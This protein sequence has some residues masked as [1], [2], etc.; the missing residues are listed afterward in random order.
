MTLNDEAWARYFDA[1]LTLKSIKQRGYAYVTSNELKKIGQREARFMA[2]LDTLRSRPQVFKDN[3]LSIFPVK[4]GKYII[5]ED[6]DRKSY[7]EFSEQLDKVPVERYD[8]LVDLRS[9][10]S[11]PRGPSLSESQAID[12]AFLSSLLKSFTADENLRLTIR[13]T[14]YSGRFDFVLPE[15]GYQVHIS[16]VQIEIDAGYESDKAIYLIEAK[17]GKRDNFHIRQL[18]YPYLEWS[19]RSQ[20]DIVP[21]FF[22]YS[23][24]K[25]CLTEFSF[26]EKFG[27]LEIVRRDC[28]TINESPISYVDISELFRLIPEGEE[29]EGIPYPQAN[30]LDKVVDAINLIG[31]GA[32]DKTQLAEFFEFEGRQGDYYAN[33]GCYLGF[34]EREGRMFVLTHL[35][36][37]FVRL[38][39]FSERARSLLSQMLTRPTFRD[40]FNLLV[41]NGFRLENIENVKIAEIIASHT[42]LTGSTPLRRAST[43]RSWIE[44]VLENCQFAAL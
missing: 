44:W 3:A 38:E 2:K 37:E 34:V 20:K 5:F 24:G 33:A 42:P 43:V 25:Y 13:S 9:F 23:N 11:Y 22:V 6:P 29:P 18:Y 15:I 1:T 10:D 31:S 30:D 7:F 35:G 32:D 12:F 4:N 19:N 8:S 21:I 39:S 17:S 41:A 36:Q 16:S 27:D 28:Y 14:L 40:V 26:G